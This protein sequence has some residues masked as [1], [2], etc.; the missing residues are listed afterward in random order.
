MLKVELEEP[1]ITEVN[2]CS[3][4]QIQQGF[5]KGKIDQVFLGMVRK[6]D[7]LKEEDVAMK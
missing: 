2:L 4:T 1:T 7:E 5:R 6:V 3:A